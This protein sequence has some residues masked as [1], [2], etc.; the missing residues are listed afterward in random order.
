METFSS[1]FF[2]AKTWISHRRRFPHHRHWF[3]YN[4]FWLPFKYRPIGCLNTEL[5]IGR[6]GLFFYFELKKRVGSC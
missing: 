2:L 4:C 1:F 3:P 5:A 6:S